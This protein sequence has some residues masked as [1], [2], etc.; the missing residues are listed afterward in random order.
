MK[1][2]AAGII[3]NKPPM[4][5][6]LGEFSAPNMPPTDMNAKATEKASVA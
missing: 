1:A 4:K 3:Q 6:A 2:G 5:N